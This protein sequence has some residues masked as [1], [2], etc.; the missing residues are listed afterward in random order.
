MRLDYFLK[1]SRLVKRRPLAKEMCDKHLVQV[2]A[3]PA[4]AG[5]ELQP[6]DTVTVTF[7]RRVVTVRVESLPEHAVTKKDAAALYS[8]LEDR[9]TPEDEWLC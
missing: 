5:R 4:K 2:N 9:Q 6:G 7:P 1:L 3:Q 8:L